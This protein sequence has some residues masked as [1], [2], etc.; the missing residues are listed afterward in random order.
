M[1][2]DSNCYV[3]RTT[4]RANET[5]KR[6]ANITSN[7]LFALGIKHVPERAGDGAV[8]ELAAAGDG[9]DA[10]DHGVSDQR[11][12]L[13][14]GVD[15]RSGGS[16]DAGRQRARLTRASGRDRGTAAHQRM[17]G[18]ILRILR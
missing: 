2:T 10:A 6:A 11:R 17:A 18:D 1:P 13:V 14:R 7:S 3:K 9:G 16:A 8:G 5:G 4:F 12:H 15:E